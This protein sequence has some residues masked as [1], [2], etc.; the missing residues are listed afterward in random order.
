MPDVL[1]SQIME[2]NSELHVEIT[3][4]LSAEDV[5]RIQNKLWNMGK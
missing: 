4:P 3:R 1:N 2:V 5:K